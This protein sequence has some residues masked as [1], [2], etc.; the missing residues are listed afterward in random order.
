MKSHSHLVMSLF[1]IGTHQ[2]KSARGCLQAVERRG[3]GLNPTNVSPASFLSLMSS[4][5]QKDNPQDKQSG[6]TPPASPDQANDPGQ[7]APQLFL[8]KA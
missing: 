7:G 1:L 6:G 8:K 5:P 4:P 2:E 3:N